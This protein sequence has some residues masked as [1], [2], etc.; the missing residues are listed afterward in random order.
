MQNISY[1]RPFPNQ[2]LDKPKNVIGVTLD[3]IKN[4]VVSRFPNPQTTANQILF[5]ILR[6]EYL[7]K[8][9]LHPIKKLPRGVIST[10]LKPIQEP[11]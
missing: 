5:M 10:N 7:L 9:E 6:L 3:T 2:K 8:K 11:I 4:S 1:N